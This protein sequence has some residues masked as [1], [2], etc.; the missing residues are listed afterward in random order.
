MNL[1]YCLQLRISSPAQ[2]TYELHFLQTFSVNSLI[3]SFMLIVLEVNFIEFFTEGA[4]PLIDVRLL[5]INIECACNASMNYDILSCF[6][7]YFT[8]TFL[9]CDINW[10]FVEIVF[11][12]FHVMITSF[13]WFSQKCF[14]FYYPQLHVSL[15]GG[16]G[17]KRQ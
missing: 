5:F 4:H 1:L 10:I 9:A 15:C 17:I 8:S 11:N 2:N 6:Q 7:L 12:Y 14:I 16:S 13:V 3:S